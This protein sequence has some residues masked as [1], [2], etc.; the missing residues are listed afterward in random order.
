VKLFSGILPALVQANSDAITAML[1]EHNPQLMIKHLD[2]SLAQLPTEVHESCLGL[3]TSIFT[4][5]PD[6]RQPWCIGKVNYDQLHEYF[7]EPDEEVV[8]QE[9]QRK[10]VAREVPLSWE[11]YLNG[12]LTTK[13]DPFPERQLY[14]MV[15]NLYIAKIK[16]DAIDFT[17][18]NEPDAMPEFCIEWML[19]KYGTRNLV[20]PKLR[21][22]I[23]SIKHYMQDPNH[24]WIQLFGEKLC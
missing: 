2:I 14:Q 1:T 21:V 8:E 9:F 15:F 3:S 16:A 11:H 24:P 5:Y 6:L 10:E 7:R 18:H 4:D 19:F 17:E 20:K 22:M 12:R 23:K 13:E